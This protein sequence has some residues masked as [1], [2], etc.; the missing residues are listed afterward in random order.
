M[1]AIRFTIA[2]ALVLSQAASA[3]E[4]ARNTK[5]SEI[6][7]AISASSTFSSQVIGLDV[8]N[9]SKQDIGKIQ[10]IV[11]SEDGHAQAYVLSVGGFLGMFER[12]V[13]VNPSAVKVSY[14]ELDKAWHA[15]MKI[16][17]DQ[18]LAAPEFQYLGRLKACV[19][20]LP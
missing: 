12:Y 18:L 7:P 10:D 4:T 15:T 8:Y 9:D 5:P 16:S 11:I 17:S 3:Q 19:N 13:A 20:I 1:S 2:T 14:S 6:F